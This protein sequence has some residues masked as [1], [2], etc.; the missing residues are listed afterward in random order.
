[1]RSVYLECAEAL[2]GAGYR[3]KGQ[4]LKSMHFGVPQIRQ[5][6]I[7][8]GIRDDLGV[9]PSHPRPQT[10]PPTLR[11]ALVGLEDREQQSRPLTA[12]QRQL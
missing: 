1:M 7:V 8:I 9:E 2:R 10:K 5:R 3:I 12:R 11:E 6:V 4:V